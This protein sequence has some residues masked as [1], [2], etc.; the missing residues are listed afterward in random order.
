MD[1]NKCILCKVNLC[2]KDSNMCKQC[3]ILDTAINDLIK[4][5]PKH[6]ADY[7]IGKSKEAGLKSRSRYM[8]AKK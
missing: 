1:D 6:A 3:S 7:I 5:S 8:V 4:R 2:I